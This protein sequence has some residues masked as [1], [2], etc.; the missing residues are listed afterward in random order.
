MVH[1]ELGTPPQLRADLHY[2]LL[3]ENW[4]GRL[5]GRRKACQGLVQLAQ[6]LT[7]LQLCIRLCPQR[8][9]VGAVN[10][11]GNLSTVMT[12]NMLHGPDPCCGSF[13]GGCCWVAGFVF[14]QV[15]AMLAASRVAPLLVA[16]SV[17]RLLQVLPYYLPA[18]VP[19]LQHI[20]G[21]SICIECC[22][23]CSL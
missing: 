12:C 4:S 6:C 7:C 16:S 11:L 17:T 2:Q 8:L 18:A 21:E 9:V 3:T 5:T 1:T 19:C 14:K 13:M 20:A 23:H 10:L 15:A 22:G